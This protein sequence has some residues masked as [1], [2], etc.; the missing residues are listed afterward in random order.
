MSSL[1][2]HTRSVYILCPFVQHTHQCDMRDCAHLE[3]AILA[4]CRNYLSL[5][6]T[7]YISVCNDNNNIVGSMYFYVAYIPIRHILYMAGG[8]QTLAVLLPVRIIY[9][10]ERRVWMG[11]WGE[12]A[13]TIQLMSCGRVRVI[14]AICAYRLCL[15][16]VWRKFKFGLFRTNDWRYGDTVHKTTLADGSRRGGWSKKCANKMYR[17]LTHTFDFS[18]L[19]G[20]VFFVDVHNNPLKKMLNAKPRETENS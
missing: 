7:R 8:T 12:D 18:P 4:P 9:K 10:N 5:G 2:S 16:G 13:T 19:K 14:A 3:I 6:N 20:L 15:C 17:L 11:W 1:S